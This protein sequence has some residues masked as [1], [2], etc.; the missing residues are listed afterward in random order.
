[1]SK[2]TEYNKNNENLRLR[3]CTENNMTPSIN[4]VSGN[5]ITLI[6]KSTMDRI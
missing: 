6:G 5:I 2:G 4:K 3:H 1:M